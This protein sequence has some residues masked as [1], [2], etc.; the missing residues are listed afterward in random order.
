MDR[1][2]FLQSVLNTL[3]DALIVIDEQGAIAYFSPAAEGTFGWS[4][5]EALGKNIREL[6]PSPY[7]E[8]HDGYLQR[9]KETGE[10]RIIGTGRVV[11]GERKDGSTFPMELSVGQMDAPE[12]RFFT[13]LVRDLTVRQMT[14]ARLHEL[15]AELVQMSRLT[16]MGNMASALAHEL[17]QPLSAIANY[18]KGSRRLIEQGEGGSERLREAIDK[19][20]DQ[21]LRAG[22]II[23]RLR[24]FVA[25]GEADRR[26]EP[27]TKLIEEASALALV[28]AHEKGVR[29]RFDLD[30]APSLVLA[31]RVEIQQVMVNLIRNAVEAMQERPRRDLAISSRMIDR[32][33]AEVAVADTGGGLSEEAAANLFKPF[34]TTK[35][36]GMGVGLSI[37]RTI[38][39][40]HGGMITAQANGEGGVTFRFTLP[41]VHPGDLHE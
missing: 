35:Q 14:D 34:V 12:G 41:R 1:S 16:T 15:Q 10:R 37:S 40:A 29:V 18:L 28:G 36:N 30:R 5:A 13:G 9:Y 25:H 31:D 39:E 8:A 17:N 33:W 21:A 19:A 7:R 24:D 32:E 11:V 6:M 20:A 27:L 38:V 23:R 3:P 22:E 4:A 2:A 26:A